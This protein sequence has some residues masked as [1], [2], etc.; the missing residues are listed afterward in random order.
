MIP[1]HFP[2]D[3]LLNIS[4][5]KCCSFLLKVILISPSWNPS[6][7][8]QA[9]CRAW[10]M[11]QRKDVV[12]YRLITAGAIEDKIFMREVSRTKENFDGSLIEMHKL[13]HDFSLF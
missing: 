6:E 8:D 9:V 10:R 12:V 5:S 2:W 3:S 7:D 1:K 4:K 13:V 11:G